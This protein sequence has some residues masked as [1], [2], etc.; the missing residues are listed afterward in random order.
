MEDENRCC[1][2]KCCSGKKRCSCS[3]LKFIGFCACVAA[4]IAFIRKVFET[5][6]EKD[7]QKNYNS[8]I[9]HYATCFNTLKEKLDHIEVHCLKL[10]TVCSAVQI[11]LEKAEIGSDLTIDISG[12]ASAVKILLPKEC[13]IVNVAEC[14]SSSVEFDPE[15]TEGVPTITLVGRMSGCAISLTKAA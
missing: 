10:R 5:V 2:K 3:F 6:N 13:N 7:S 12:L 9:R 14:K 1:E 8:E 4:F 11:D 15:K